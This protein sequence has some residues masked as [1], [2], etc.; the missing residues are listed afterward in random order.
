[1]NKLA[2]FILTD[3]HFCY[4]NSV[5]NPRCFCFERFSSRKLILFC[6][7]ELLFLIIVL[8]ACIP[9]FPEESLRT[10]LEILYFNI[11]NLGFH[12]VHLPMLCHQFPKIWHVWTPYLG[13]ITR[14]T[15]ES[16]RSQKL[17]NSETPKVSWRMKKK[18]KTHE[19]I[20][21]F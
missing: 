11:M 9:L 7:L 14:F 8:F 21:H 19:N 1:M 16:R 20:C 12:R 18:N 3:T 15:S 5:S 6:A 4:R 10:Q 17:Q 2:Q 13:A